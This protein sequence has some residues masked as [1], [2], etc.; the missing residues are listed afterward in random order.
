MYAAGL[1]DAM[2][3]GSNNLNYLYAEMDA[4]N[5]NCDCPPYNVW[6]KVRNQV[7]VYNWGKQST[8]HCCTQ[9]TEPPWF[10]GELSCRSTFFA[11]C[12]EPE[13]KARAGYTN[14]DDKV[15]YWSGSYVHTKGAYCKPGSFVSSSNIGAYKTGNINNA[16]AAC[17]ADPN[18]R[19]YTMRRSKTQYLLK[20]TVSG[21][22]SASGYECYAKQD[23]SQHC[24]GLCATLM[25]AAGF[26]DGYNKQNNVVNYA[27][28]L[29]DASNANCDCPPYNVVGKIRRGA[30]KRQYVK[31]TKCCRYEYTEYHTKRDTILPE[32]ISSETVERDF[33]TCISNSVVWCSRPDYL[34]CVDRW[35]DQERPGS[36]WADMCTNNDWWMKQNDLHD[37][38]P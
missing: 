26:N 11:S 32:W 5:A 14:P 16:K 27:Y 19:G 36:I 8:M 37:I 33:E 3:Y 29:A 18:C 12:S 9:G 15:T 20:N 31:S 30:A 10:R 25:Y 21:T 28:A 6:G 35:S 4:R 34:A 38:R 17:D 22:I 2:K 13:W 1:K 23:L 24:P 7:Q